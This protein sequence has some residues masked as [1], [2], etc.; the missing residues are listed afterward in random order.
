MNFGYISCPSAGGGFFSNYFSVLSTMI[1]CHSLNLI[2]YVNLNKTAFATGFTQDKGAPENA[3]NPWDWWFTQDTPTDDDHI[4]HVEYTPTINFSHGLKVW[5]RKDIP[6]ARMV[7]DKYIHIKPHILMA[8]NDYY[9]KYLKDHIVLGVMARGSEMNP[10]HPQYGNQTIET[11]IKSTKKI[12]KKHPEIDVIFLV[13]E[14]ANYIPIFLK[15]FPDTLYLNDVFRRTTE[16]IEEMVKFS[17]FYCTANVRPDHSRVLGEEC[18]LQALL[19][20]KCNYLLV[21]QCGTSS[22]A[23]LYANDNLKNVIYA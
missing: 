13:T 16:T 14:D 9:N 10:I 8:V 18:L 21:K 1:T 11:W 12:L 2:P 23:I 20:S 17:L 19:L 6:H 5:K 3:D 15:E 4:V 22:A 7:V